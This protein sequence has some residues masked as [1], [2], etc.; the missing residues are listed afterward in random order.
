MCQVGMAFL[1]G[2]WV[3]VKGGCK[4]VGT[5]HA[6]GEYGVKL[7]VAELGGVTGSYMGT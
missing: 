4:W 6:G 1:L 5:R 2:R 7:M 3:A